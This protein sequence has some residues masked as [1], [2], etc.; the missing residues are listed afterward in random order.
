MPRIKK[1]P[2]EEALEIAQDL[3]Q[4]TPEGT[5]QSKLSKNALKK[6]RE[7][8]NTESLADEVVRLSIAKQVLPAFSEICQALVE[9]AKSGSPAQIALSM[10][11][12]GKI[13]S[14][15]RKYSKAEGAQHVHL[16]FD[17]MS[18]T[19]L[20]EE[21][22]IQLKEMIR[23]QVE[24]PG[25]YERIRKSVL[26]ALRD[27]RKRRLQEA[28]LVSKISGNGIRYSLDI[29]RQLPLDDLDSESNQPTTPQPQSH[30]EAR[31]LPPPQETETLPR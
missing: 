2:Q 3:S 9:K 7:L 15:M 1:T 21:S 10:E 18:P 12:I 28:F 29:P 4:I 26:T 20:V 8:S 5:L 13:S 30:L 16:H 31:I 11:L 24:L 22:F 6:F 14:F 23:I 19:Q 17:K 27:Y 25:G